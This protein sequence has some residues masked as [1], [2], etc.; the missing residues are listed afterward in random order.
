MHNYYDFIGRNI[1]Q[2]RLSA[3][4]T[5]ERLAHELGVSL[6]VISRTETGRTMLSVHRL[7]ELAQVLNVF[8]GDFLREP[9]VEE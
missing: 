2:A 4:Y 8:V 7:M 9:E 6:S 5:Q 3:G 1:Q